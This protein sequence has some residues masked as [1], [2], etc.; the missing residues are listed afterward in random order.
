VRTFNLGQRKAGV[1]TS[2]EK[3]VH[4]DGRNQYGEKTSSGIYFYS[5]QAGAFTARKK[6]IV[7]E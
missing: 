2:M 6:M 7:A 3:A 1:Y 4:W 5:I